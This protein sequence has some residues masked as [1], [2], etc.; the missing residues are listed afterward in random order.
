VAGSSIS[1]GV[2]ALAGDILLSPLIAAFERH[3]LIKSRDV[4]P[5]SRTR[6]IIGKHTENDALLGAV[7][8]ALSHHGRRQ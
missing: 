8:L 1:R 2:T 7:G 3:T 6:I 4:A 5:G